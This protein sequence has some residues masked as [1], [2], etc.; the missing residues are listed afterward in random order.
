M[1]PRPPRPALVL[2]LLAACFVSAFGEGE[3]AQPTPERPGQAGERMR[4]AALQVAGD[5]QELASRL[6]DEVGKARDEIRMIFSGT[7]SERQ[8]S[9]TL[10]RIKAKGVSAR[11]FM[12]LWGTFGSRE[13]RRGL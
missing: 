11:G 5:D 10:E 4:Q 8:I 12:D 7:L 1:A 13:T 9:A 3:P 2:V 6:M